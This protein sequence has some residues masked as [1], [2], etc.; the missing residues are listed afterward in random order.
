MSQREKLNFSELETLI[1]G[2]I[3]ITERAAEHAEDSQVSTELRSLTAQTALNGLQRFAKG[4][5]PPLYVEEVL[6]G[7]SPQ[8]TQGLGELLGTLNPEELRWNHSVRTQANRVIEFVA[9]APG[10]QEVQ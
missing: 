7:L 1:S 9:K 5:Q 4:Q 3:A 10:Q 8:T 6:Q 2:Q